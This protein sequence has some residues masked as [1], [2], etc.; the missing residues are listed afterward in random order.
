[1]SHITDEQVV[2]H[3]NESCHVSMSQVTMGWLRLVAS[4]K[5]Q[6][7]FAEYRLFYRALLQ[8]RPIILRSLLIVAPSYHVLSRRCRMSLTA[9]Q[10]EP[11]S[12]SVKKPSSVSDLPLGAADS[13]HIG[14]N[15]E[16]HKM[17]SP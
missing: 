6:I 4:L 8:K 9:L 1:M 14:L 15:L 13:L 17:L 12:V 11:C 16:R 7:S 3:V 10:K 2:S 5:L